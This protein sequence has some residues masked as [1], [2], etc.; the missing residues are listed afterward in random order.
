MYRYKPDRFSPLGRAPYT[1][2]LLASGESYTIK[3]LV[4]LTNSNTSTVTSAI[5]RAADAG[6]VIEVTGTS[7]NFSRNTKVK[8]ISLGTPEQAQEVRNSLVPSKDPRKSQYRM[9]YRSKSQNDNQETVNRNS[10]PIVK[11]GNN[12]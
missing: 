2:I 6:C 11:I 4:Q 5:K 8:M 3:R 7:K 10:P 9:Q 1:V 12:D